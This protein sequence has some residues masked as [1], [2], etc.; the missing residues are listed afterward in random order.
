MNHPI[1]TA[2]APILL[3]GGGEFRHA[4]LTLAQTWAGRAVAADSG[5]L[6][7]LRHG[8]TP[9]AV[10]GDFDSLPAETRAALSPDT[11]HHIA[12][13]DSTDF[14]KC[15]RNIEAPLILGLGFLGARV[16]HQLSV[17]N[18]L[19]ARADR[20]CIL[21]G[22]E[23]VVFHAPPRLA[24][25]LAAGTRVSLFPLRPVTG[26]STGL[27]WPIHGIDFTP[28]GRVGTSNE[29][30]ATEVTLEM[31]GPGMLVILPRDCLDAAVRA[32]LA[33]GSAPSTV[34]A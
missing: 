19:A 27:R 4:D 6:V 24:L 15:L 16:D 25:D 10:I 5:A 28:G 34:R 3:V 32:V 29:A 21:I 14:D 9:E 18:R 31:D 26:Q 13:Q 22:R 23:D 8:V 33:A 12:E 2:E 11:L 20:P 7:L 1:I 30:L 17:F